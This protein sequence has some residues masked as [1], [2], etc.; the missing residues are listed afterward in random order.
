MPRARNIKPGFFE[1]EDL[2]DIDPLG[3][4]LF[5]G[6]WLLAD[7]EGR[8]EYR[9]KKIK[10]QL[11]PYED[12]DV[13]F[14]CHQLQSLNFLTIY[15]ITGTQYIQIDS[16]EKHQN[17]HPNEKE[18]VLPGPENEKSSRVMDESSRADTMNPDTMNPESHAAKPPSDCPYHDLLA[19][20][21]ETLPELPKVRK[22]TDKRRRALRNRWED[23]KELWIDG[24]DGLTWWRRFF[25]HVR[26]S[27]FLM[28]EK[29]D[30]SASFDFL[31][32][33]SK[34]VNVVE[35]TYHKKGAA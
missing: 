30:W 8:L 19:L 24:E 31:T 33:Q 21:H 11:F 5:I 10:G 16:F 34:F 3:R 27:P 2:P 28:G 22:F 14:Y 7:R 17:P 25:E 15:E 20:Y 6:L 12:C 29:N 35:G 26:E 13:N 9:P 32:T 18:S 23:S 4:L 1:N